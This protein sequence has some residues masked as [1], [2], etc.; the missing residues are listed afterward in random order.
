MEEINA[1]I[2]EYLKNDNRVAIIKLPKKEGVVKPTE[3][4]VMTIMNMDESQI[5]PYEE[6]KAAETLIRN[7]LKKGS[8]TNRS[9]NE[10]TDETTL[11][12]SNGLKVTYKITD[13]KNDEILME[14]ISFGGTNLMNDADYK[15][16]HLA[17]RGVTEAGVAGM[18]KNE[19]DK[20]MT[21]KIARVTPMVSNITEG[22]SGS[23]APKDLETMMQLTVANMTDLNKN[24]QAYQGYVSKQKAMM[25]NFLNNPNFYFSNE[26]YGYLNADNPRFFGLVPNDELWNQTDYN[27]AFE[28]FKQRFANASDFHFYFIGNIDVKTFEDY[29]QTYLA[30]LPSSNLKEKAVDSP[31]RMK[32]GD[33]KKVVNKGKDPKSNVSIMYYGDADYNSDEALAMKALGEVLQIKLTEEVREKESGVYS[34]RANSSMSKMPSGSYNMNISFPCSPENVDKLTEI[35]LNEIKKIIDIG[36]SQEDLDKF[37]ENQRI[38][39]REDLKTNKHWADNFKG[40]F[41]NSRSSEWINEYINKIDKLTPKDLQNVAKKYLSKDKTIGVLMPE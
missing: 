35:S 13:F 12:L 3:E 4:Q 25:G 28:A 30:A 21:G 37:K 2:K 31:Y 33:I 38:K 23:C 5:K 27:S 26:L 40:A 29:C 18:N 15:K 39:D 6:V 41:T 24:E 32:K 8:I 11:T 14:G 34:I 16:L 1:L 10:K 22:I 20:F 7:P 36:P 19:L 9:K 17:F